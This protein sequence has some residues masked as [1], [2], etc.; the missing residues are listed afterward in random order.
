MLP[1]ASDE[2]GAARKKSVVEAK[3]GLV[4]CNLPNA[5]SEAPGPVAAAS[6]S[7]LTTCR[8]G[9]AP[10]Y[11]P[12]REF[13]SGQ[14]LEVVGQNAQGDYLLVRDPA[15][16]STVCWLESE[17]VE[18]PAQPF[19]LPVSTP[20]STPTLV[21]CPS[22]VPSG[23]TPISCDGS[24]PA[25]SGCP[26]P[27]GGGPTPFSCPTQVYYPP[28]GDNPTPVPGGPPPVVGCPTPLGGGPTPVSCPTAVP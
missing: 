16:P 20:P 2:V 22:P 12:V 17:F 9:P 10:V 28:P 8:A 1:L 4:A 21:G 19:D 26:T 11:D 13:T 15:D 6:V 5:A 25:G 24:I 3:C 27:I 23:P 18:L 7:E 14:Q